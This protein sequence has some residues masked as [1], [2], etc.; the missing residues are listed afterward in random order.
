MNLTP[1]QARQRLA[2]AIS[3][4][5][6]LLATLAAD[7]GEMSRTAQA[8]ILARLDHLEAQAERYRAVL[9]GRCRICGALLSDPVSVARCVGPECWKQV[10]GGQS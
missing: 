5:D 1:T 7:D 2:Y 3:A 6:Q 8:S 10:G 9:V 4:G